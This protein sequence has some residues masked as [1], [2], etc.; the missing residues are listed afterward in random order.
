MQPPCRSAPINLLECGSL[1]SIPSLTMLRAC[2]LLLW[3]MLPSLA[4]AAGARMTMLAGAAEP[5]GAFDLRIDDAWPNT[6]V[7]RLEAIEVSG[8]D[9]W[10]IARDTSEAAVCGQTLTPYSLDTRLLASNRE[11]IELVGVQRLHYVV[12]STANLRLRGFDLVAMG[13]SLEL[14]PE[15]ESGYWWADPAASNP[16]AGRGIGLNLERQGATL[17]GVL[18]GY[19][20]SGEPEWS[21]GA[22]SI[23]PYFSRLGLSRLSDGSG[24]AQPYREPRSLRPLGALLLEPA[25]PSRARVWLVYQ[26]SETADLSLRQIDL[27]RFGFDASPARVWSAGEWLLLPPADET[28]R[29]IARQF[30]FSHVEGNASGFTLMDP[31]RG[32]ALVCRMGSANSERVP[33]RCELSVVSEDKATTHSF[34]RIGLRRMQGAAPDGGSVRLIHLDAN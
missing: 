13:E 3:F 31:E 6:C 15:P 28:G 22:G 26:D 21:L 17:S 2:A 4:S 11:G 19:D 20:V 27:V 33:E 24:P 8:P 16:W 25:S 1:L 9:L 23:G 29:S 7:P 32:A 5:G 12:R 10:V 30:A 34:D 18:F 14:A